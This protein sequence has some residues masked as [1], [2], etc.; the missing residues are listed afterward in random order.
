[1]EAGDEYDHFG[2]N[3]AGR[4]RQI[5]NRSKKHAITLQFNV[6]KL[7]HDVEIEL[8]EEGEQQAI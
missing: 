6:H 7:F 8:L 3:L 4:L 2:A 5:K 1:V